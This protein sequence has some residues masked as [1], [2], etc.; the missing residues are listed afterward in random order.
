MTA[1]SGKLATMPSSRGHCGCTCLMPRATGSVPLGQVRHTV[2]RPRMR[3]PGGQLSVLWQ[4]TLGPLMA[5]R[6]SLAHSLQVSVHA[7]GSAHPVGTGEG[8][9]LPVAWTQRTVAPGSH[10]L[11]R[12]TA[13]PGPTPVAFASS[14]AGTRPLPPGP[15][16]TLQIQTTAAR[17]LAACPWS[18]G[19]SPIGDR[20]A[21]G[22]GQPCEP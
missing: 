7:V 6:A 11:W 10:S 13:P 21:A 12:D 16:G 1:G 15:L 2:A 14:Q 4:D 3:P 17:V 22:P 19:G 9:P 20:G 18:G 8:H 5:G